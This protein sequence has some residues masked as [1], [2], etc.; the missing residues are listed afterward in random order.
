MDKEDIAKLKTQLDAERKKL[1]GG[2]DHI[3]RDMLNKSQRD[4]SGDL[5]GYSF[6]MADQATDNFATE[7]GF[8][9]ASNEQQRLNQIDDALKRIEEGVFGVCEECKKSIPM[10]RLKAMPSA[11]YC[12]KCQEIVEARERGGAQSQ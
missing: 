3:E 10:K 2:L 4:A 12:I 5:S 6:H 8:D 7:F 11:R 9:I 1:M